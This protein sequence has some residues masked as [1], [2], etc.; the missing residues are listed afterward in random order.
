MKAPSD[1]ER[2]ALALMELM[3]T[4]KAIE[5]AQAARGNLRYV[6]IGIEQALAAL[7]AANAWTKGEL[8]A[9]MRTDLLALRATRKEE[10]WTPIN[11]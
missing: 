11:F 2:A 7:E 9:E 10:Q 6:T 8:S 1:E 3:K 4:K 5:F